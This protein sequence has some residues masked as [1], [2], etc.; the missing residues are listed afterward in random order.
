MRKVERGKPSAS[1]ADM[2]N[3]W[4]ALKQVPDDSVPF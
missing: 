1:V 3:V 4:P 2:Q